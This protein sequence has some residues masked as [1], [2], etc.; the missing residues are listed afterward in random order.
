MENLFYKHEISKTY[1]LKGIG[2]LFAHVAE[3]EL[4][5]S[6]GRKVAKTAAP[7]GGTAEAKAVGST[8][9]WDGDWLDSIARR[10]VLLYPRESRKLLPDVQAELMNRR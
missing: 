5:K 8:T 3:H 6:E 4:I 9:L 2:K 10:P 1:D 7:S